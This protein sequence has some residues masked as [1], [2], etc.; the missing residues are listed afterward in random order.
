[1]KITVLRSILVEGNHVEAGSTVETTDAIAGVLIA[2]QDAI[3][4]KAVKAE[5]PA[6]EPKKT[7]ATK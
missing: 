3:A 2:S 4:A 6:V 1:M 7:K 5:E